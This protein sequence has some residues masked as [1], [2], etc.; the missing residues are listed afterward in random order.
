[1]KV[2]LDTQVAHISSQIPNGVW[3][4][5]PGMIMIALGRDLFARLDQQD[6]SKEE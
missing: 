6:K 2:F 4:L 3:I 1:M 5:V